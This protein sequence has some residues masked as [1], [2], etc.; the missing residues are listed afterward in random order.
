MAINRDRIE[1]F[2]HAFVM[3]SLIVATIVLTS[4]SRNFWI[5]MMFGWIGIAG[6]AFYWNWLRKKIEP[7]K[8]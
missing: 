1:L 7:P 4:I 2:K 5:Q 3:V 8:T 6:V